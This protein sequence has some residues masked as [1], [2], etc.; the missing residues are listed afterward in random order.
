VR[1]ADKRGTQGAG[2]S[3]TRSA[4][5]S[6]G[7]LLSGKGIAQSSDRKP[8]TGKDA[9]FLSRYSYSRDYQEF[10]LAAEKAMTK[11]KIPPGL[12]KYIADYFKAIHPW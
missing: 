2:S 3:T 1:A 11:E 7:G 4:E 8:L 10:R 12:R 6:S 9:A 5:S